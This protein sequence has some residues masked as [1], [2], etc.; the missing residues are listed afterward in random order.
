MPE[1]VTIDLLSP[2]EHAGETIRA[3]TLRPPALTDLSIGAAVEWHRTEGGLLFPIIRNAIVR[4]YLERCVIA[5]A[6]AAPFLLRLRLTDAV[7]LRDAMMRL[8]MSVHSAA[9]KIF[10]LGHPS[11]G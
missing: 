10:I 4:T 1:T 7:R 3:V 11:V 2:I 6:D 5:P 8:W 9:L